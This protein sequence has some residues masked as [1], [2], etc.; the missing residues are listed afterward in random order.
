MDRVGFGFGLG[1]SPAPGDYTY[2]LIGVLRR[3]SSRASLD[4]PLARQLTLNVYRHARDELL[5]SSVARLQLPESASTNP[6]ASLTHSELES[7][8][9]GLAVL[10]RTLVAHPVA[11]TMETVRARPETVVNA[12]TGKQVER[13]KDENPIFPRD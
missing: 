12:R 11:P 6:L 8:V 1:S 5:G 10:V 2:F 13:K 4:R 3:G 9:L 7:L